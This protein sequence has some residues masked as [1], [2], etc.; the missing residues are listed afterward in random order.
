MGIAGLLPLLKAAAVRVHVSAYRGQ[1]VAI[2]AYGW[3]H[4][5]AYN[6]AAELAQG[7]YT[8]GYAEL[9]N[10]RAVRARARALIPLCWRTRRQVRAVLHPPRAAAAARRRG[11]SLCL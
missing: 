8:D 9:R 7:V 4:R 6:C 10:L 2:D 3:L 1:R 11:A 5:G